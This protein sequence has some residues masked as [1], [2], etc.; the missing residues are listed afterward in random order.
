MKQPLVLASVLILLAGCAT[1]T[2]SN[3]RRGRI[4]NHDAP[5]PAPVAVKP[6]AKPVA[7]PAP[8]TPKPAP[9]VVAAP[10]VP[11]AKP[12]APA[13]VPTPPPA[14]PAPAAPAATPVVVAPAAPAPAA[15]P[16]APAAAAP[17]V[18]RRNGA[19]VDVSWT[20]P[21]SD[22]GYKAIEIM[23]NERSEAQGRARVR[24]VRSTVT[25]LQ[26]TVPDAQSDYWYWIKL[27]R[28]D[29]T[30]QNIGPVA[31]PAKG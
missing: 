31:A 27:T 12:A 3:L 13:P 7:K 25:S 22:I 20:L 6:A 8:V 26:D 1:Q 18:A 29:G 10:V 4:I 23:R 5:A 21:V 28:T 9:A 16:V 11:A 15:P 24:A 14:A 2:Q 30:I 17:V 19:V